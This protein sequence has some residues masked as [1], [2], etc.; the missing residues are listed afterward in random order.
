MWPSH[1]FKFCQ[2]FDPFIHISF[3][4][5]FLT[6]VNSQSLEFFTSGRLILGTHK[7]RTASI[8]AGDIDNDGDIDIL[9]TNRGSENEICLNDGKGNFSKSIGFGTK[10]DSTIDVEVAD[11]DNDNDFDLG[12]LL[13]SSNNK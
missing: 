3:F 5:L 8:G 4:L 7:E 9:I 2:K 11:M 6:S 12:S 1:T 10:K 13:K